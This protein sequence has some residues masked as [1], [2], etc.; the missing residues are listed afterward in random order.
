MNEDNA[1]TPRDPQPETKRT[2][3]RTCVGCGE[4]GDAGELVRLV[5]AEGDVAFD[6]AGGAFGRGAHVHARPDCLEKAPRGIAR[7][8]RRDPGVDASELGRR[9]MN[10]CDARMAG[11]MMSARRLRA[12]AVGAD[13][14]LEAIA[15]GA[16]SG[17]PVLAV[18]ATDAGVIAARAEVQRAV[19]AGQAIA[20]NTKND[21]GGLLG[22]QAVAICAVRH[23]AIAA[24]LKRM[25]ATADAGVATTK[26]PHAVARSEDRGAECSRRPEAR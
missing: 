1:M 7:A 12:V 23:P 3:A 9:L 18:V 5:V 4:R 26:R 17:Q 14:S 22:E 20:W 10:A 19:A 24:E 6:L 11:L 25:R 13:A 2:L 16:R 8:F 15:G 21:L